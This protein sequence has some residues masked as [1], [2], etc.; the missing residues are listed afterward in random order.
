VAGSEFDFLA[1]REIG[2]TVMDHALTGLRRDGDGRAWARLRS[3]ATEV[4]LWAG[5]GYS[6]LQVF[7]GD[8]LPPAQ[9]RRAI[10]IEP[11]TCP[12]NAFVTGE[13]LITLD[14]GA[15]V[16]RSWGV[17]ASLG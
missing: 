6:W 17:T 10:A 5:D 13:D 8:P 3:G 1:G 4:A 16:T 7:T 15:S 2:A 9:R 11:M 14:P 12:P